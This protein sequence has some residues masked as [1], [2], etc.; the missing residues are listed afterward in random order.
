[1][2]RFIT[3]YTVLACIIDLQKKQQDQL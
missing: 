3:D 1:L 2:N